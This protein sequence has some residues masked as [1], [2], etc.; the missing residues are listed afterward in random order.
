MAA[1]G[2]GAAVR[3]LRRDCAAETLPKRRL[4]HV[5]MRPGDDIRADRSSCCVRQSGW[6]GARGSASPARKAASAISRICD[7]SVSAAALADA[8]LDYDGDRSAR[9]RSRR[10]RSLLKTVDDDAWPL[11]A[12]TILELTVCCSCRAGAGRWMIPAPPRLMPHQPHLQ[13]RKAIHSL[14]SPAVPRRGR[15]LRLRLLR[16]TNGGCCGAVQT[17]FHPPCT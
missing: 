14:P 4:E 15:D 12:G 6:E 2:P 11:L 10:R 16:W 5:A 17:T 8:R 13:R 7:R 9:V 3:T 1:D